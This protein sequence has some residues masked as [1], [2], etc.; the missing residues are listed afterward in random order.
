MRMAAFCSGPVNKA[1]IK[2]TIMESDRFLICAVSID[3]LII[4]PKQKLYG[5]KPKKA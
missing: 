1:M 5:Y 4:S 2:P 3:T